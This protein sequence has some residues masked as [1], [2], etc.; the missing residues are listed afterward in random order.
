MITASLAVVNFGVNTAQTAFQYRQVP[1]YLQTALYTISTIKT[2][3]VKAKERRIALSK[4]LDEDELA[5]YDRSVHIVEEVL[6]NYEKAVEYARSKQEQNNGRV[7]VRAR[8][9]WIIRDSKSEET[10]RSFLT[11]HHQRMLQCTIRSLP[12]RRDSQPYG[13]GQQSVPVNPRL[14][15]GQLDN[16]RRSVAERRKEDRERLAIARCSITDNDKLPSFSEQCTEEQQEQNN[17][18]PTKPDFDPNEFQHLGFRS[19]ER[20][21][22]NPLVPTRPQRPVERL[23]A[24][25]TISLPVRP[26]ASSEPLD[27]LNLD[28]PMS[29]SLVNDIAAVS[30]LEV[31][32][33]DQPNSRRVPPLR[34]DSLSQ[35][36]FL[37]RSQSI[38]EPGTLPM[39][40]QMPSDPSDMPPPYT[41]LLPR[42]NYVQNEKTDERPKS[43]SSCVIKP[44]SSLEAPQG[45][46]QNPERQTY[47]DTPL[48]Y[49]SPPNRSSSTSTHCSTADGVNPT[50]SG[51][52]TSQVTS[53]SISLSPRSLRS[54]SNPFGSTR[55]PDQGRRLSETDRIATSQRSFAGHRQPIDVRWQT[56][57]NNYDLQRPPL[58]ISRQS[59][60]SPQSSG[61]RIEHT[62]SVSSGREQDGRSGHKA[63]VKE[64]YQL[65]QPNF[66]AWSS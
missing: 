15:S 33:P 9:M 7:G 20:T 3:I 32:L 18:R 50:P 66:I 55:M 27:S 2:D 34:T 10:A 22:S 16:T 53:R 59:T 26:L 8:G 63:Y 37:S 11:L 5:E 25:S 4:E 44:S 41:S 54:P 30:N 52:A 36:G 56:S 65:S 1:I 29:W 39:S 6:D 62:D 47:D 28:R 40:P 31:H 45:Q 12:P 14:Y 13:S 61:P 64:I 48:A 35:T 21:T 23:V 38:P 51:S 42:R 58:E 57:S 49:Y 24:R 43:G 60:V 19:V 46:R 17:S